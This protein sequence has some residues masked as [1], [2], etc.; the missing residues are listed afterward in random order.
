[1][2]V[3]REEPTEEEA[4]KWEGYSMKSY[5]DATEIKTPKYQASVISGSQAPLSI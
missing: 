5:Q 4:E 1:M 3:L 2:S